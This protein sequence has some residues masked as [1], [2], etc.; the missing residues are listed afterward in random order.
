[1]VFV[2]LSAES[3]C[4]SVCLFLPHVL[5]LFFVITSF[6]L[7]HLSLSLSDITAMVDWGKTPSYLLT[8]SLSLARSLSDCY[9]RTG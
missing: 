4:V 8:L 6:I 2:S 5:V 9:N 3:T 1:M 7:T